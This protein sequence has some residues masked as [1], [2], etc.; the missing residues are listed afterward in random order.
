VGA[1]SF[2]FSLLS[3]LGVESGIFYANLSRARLKQRTSSF[4]IRYDV[5]ISIRQI[6]V[7]YLNICASECCD[8]YKSSRLTWNRIVINSMVE[9]F[10]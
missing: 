10:E 6:K 1:I 8:S 9:S 2:S 4:Q 5:Y 7:A 3:V